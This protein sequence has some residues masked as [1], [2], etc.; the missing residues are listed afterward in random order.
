MSL[1]PNG[2][3][4]YRGKKDLLP[5]VRLVDNF[6]AS[7]EYV[8]ND[9]SVFTFLTNKDA[10]RKKLIRI[11]LNEPSFWTEVLQE[12]KKDVLESA[13]AVNG[14][15]IVV[16]Y[17]SDV[18]NVLQLRDLKTGT[19]LHLLPLDIG[20]V[21][22]ISS[23]RKDIVIFFGF[24]SFLIPGIIYMCNLKADVPEMRIFREIV[25]PGFDRIEFET[26]QVNNLLSICSFATEQHLVKT[27]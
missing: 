24:T 10:P 26:S 15:Q 16:N 18:K 19:F 1:F 25:V 12:D 3:E 21:S 20:S 5:F 2:L 22:E 23:R 11:D 9:D 14:N 7:Y 4:G 17:L 6:D 8:A 27:L 13:V